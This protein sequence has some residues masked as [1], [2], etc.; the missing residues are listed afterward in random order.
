MPYQITPVV[1]S[2]IMRRLR[3]P[4]TLKIKKTDFMVFKRI[5]KASLW[6]VFLLLLFL[7][8]M[9]ILVPVYVFDE[10]EP[11][12]GDYLHNPYQSIDSASW[13]ICNFHGHTRQ[14]S[15]ITN[16]RVNENMVYDSMY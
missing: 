7:L 4:S 9:N 10:P 1:T 14:Y 8:S 3:K 5:L 12:H 6:L 13:K 11:F 15:G 2:A 16:G